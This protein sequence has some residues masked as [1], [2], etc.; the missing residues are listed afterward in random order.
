MN[1][2]NFS[3]D[4]KCNEQLRKSFFELAINV[5]GISFESWYQKGFWSNRYI[6]YSYEERGKVI[7]NVS[8]NLIDLIINGEKKRAIQIGT[9]MTHPEYRK[10]GLSA[11]LMNKVLEEYE[12]R[13]DF[14]YLFANHSVLDFY[15]KFGYKSVNEYL[16]SMEFST[17]QSEYT[18]IRKLHGHISEDLS[19]IYQFASD[20]VPVSQLFGTENTQ[21]ILMFYCMNVFYNDI[22]YLEREG[23]IVIFKKTDKQ[24]DIYDII[25]KRDINIEEILTKIADIHT[26]KIIFH[27][28]PDYKG[29]HIDSK[30]FKGEEVLFVK[31]NG[32]VDVPIRVK[33]PLTSQA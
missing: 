11:R 10:R 2:F 28:T 1:R 18:A 27:Y 30:M 12:D 7:S 20:R 5:F 15:P 3:K 26:N 31:T 22:Y 6:P 21:G 9:V 13:Y 33:H 4:Y 19:F 29:V 17:N 14:M 24:I 32:K 16:F 23:V 25:S 8:V